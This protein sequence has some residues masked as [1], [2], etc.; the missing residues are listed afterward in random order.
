MKKAALGGSCCGGWDR[1]TD[2]QVMSL[3]SYHCSTPRSNF[4]RKAT[5]W[6]IFPLSRLLARRLQIV[7][8]SQKRVQRYNKYFKYANFFTFFCKKSAFFLHLSKFICKFVR[9]FAFGNAIASDCA[10]R[11]NGDACLRSPKKRHDVSR[12]FGVPCGLRVL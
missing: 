3:T 12:F 5:Y 1:T 10:G 7:A 8:N 4:F 2:L 9:F 11:N 6:A